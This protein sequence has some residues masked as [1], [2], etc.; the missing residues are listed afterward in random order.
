MISRLTALALAMGPFLV[1]CNETPTQGDENPTAGQEVARAEVRY[2]LIS[3][4]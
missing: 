2:Y 4:A 3:E 1:G